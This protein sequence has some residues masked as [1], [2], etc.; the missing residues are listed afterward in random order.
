[1][2]RRTCLPCT[3]LPHT[4]HHN[5]PPW[6]WSAETGQLVTRVG[7][8]RVVDDVEFLPFLEAQ[9]ILR[10]GLVVIQGN[11]ER[12]TSTYG[13]QWGVEGTRLSPP[14]PAPMGA[15]HPHRQHAPH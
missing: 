9:I 2:D 14:H 8:S 3:S 13:T 4:Q 11:E 10:P 1:M 12:H 6:P 15:A 5:P 7:S